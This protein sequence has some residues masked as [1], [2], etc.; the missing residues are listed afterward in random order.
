MMAEDVCFETAQAE[1]APVIGHFILEFAT[2]EEFVHQ[3]LTWYLRKTHL[4]E[5]D[6]E[7]VSKTRLNLFER[8]MLERL[9]NPKQRKSL[10]KA[11]AGIHNLRPT[12]NLLAHNALG[13]EFARHVNGDFKMIGIV[14]SD[15]RRND[16][17]IDLATLKTRLATV[18]SHRKVLS[19][20]MSVFYRETMPNLEGDNAEAD[21]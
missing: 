17:S 5:S 15:V 21:A 20:V 19:D 7:L 2:V 3:V 8:I 16:K 18:I 4:R 12:R 6:I 13:L 14:V 1:W 10:T 9:T 11:V